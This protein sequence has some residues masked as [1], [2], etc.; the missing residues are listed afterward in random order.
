MGPRGML[1]AGSRGMLTAGWRGGRALLACAT[2]AGAVVAG[3]IR[4][5][6]IMAGAIAGCGGGGGGRVAAPPVDPRGVVACLFQEAG[7]DGDDVL[8]AGELA[9]A[10]ALAAAVAPLDADGD[11]GVSRGELTAWLTAVQ[12]SRI[13]VQSLVVVVTHR[14]RPLPAATVRLVPLP[15]MG[16][17]VSPAEGQSDADGAAPCGIPGSP[18]PGVNC[19]L[20]R[21][22]ITGTGTDGRPLGPIYNTRTRLGL[23]VGGDLP[24]GG[25]ATFALE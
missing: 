21:V 1:T 19:G 9:A 22:E 10:P 3:A 24:A 20:Y 16:G 14:R 7:T 6:L 23:A 5:A 11:G 17:A 2:P 12:E 8:S 18:H 13:A 25:F 15:C 4:A